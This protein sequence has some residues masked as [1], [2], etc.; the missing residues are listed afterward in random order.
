MKSNTVYVRENDYDLLVIA[1]GKVTFMD[2]ID[3][4]KRYE[5]VSSVNMEFVRFEDTNNELTCYGLTV[6]LY[7]YRKFYIDE[8]VLDAIEHDG[9]V[10]VSEV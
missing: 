3:A 5:A 6:T 10:K 1:D 4:C 9:I 2:V 7:G 8:T